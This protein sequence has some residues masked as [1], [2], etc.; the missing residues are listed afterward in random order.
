[1]GLPEKSPKQ[2]KQLTFQGEFHAQNAQ[3]HC[4][5]QQVF[6]FY[7]YLFA[8]APRASPATPYSNPRMERPASTA[9]LAA[10]D[11]SAGRLTGCTG[12]V[13]AASGPLSSV[14]CHL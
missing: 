5:L 11:C 2:R 10:K 12:G 9:P 14:T 7:M 1:M 13:P 8:H 4:C 6:H 3:F